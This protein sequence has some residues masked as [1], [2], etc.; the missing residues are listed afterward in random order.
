MYFFTYGQN[1]RRILRFILPISDPR[2]IIL[3]TNN[4]EYIYDYVLSK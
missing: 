4:Y 1:L 3:N 2:E